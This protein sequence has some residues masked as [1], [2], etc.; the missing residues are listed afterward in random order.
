MDIKSTIRLTNNVY[1][2]EIDLYEL[3]LVEQDVINKFGEPTIDCG[4]SFDDQMGLTFTLD[5]DERKFPSQ[6][7][8]KKS[9]DRAD[10]PSDADDRA[11]LWRDTIKTRI[12]TA[13]T[14]LRAL[15]YDNLGTEIAP[16]PT[17]D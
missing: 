11:A 2:A 14:A 4:G 7:P 17:D 6:F 5:T 16:V 1:H 12:D 13:V 10:Y 9:W 8:C 15:T 3:T